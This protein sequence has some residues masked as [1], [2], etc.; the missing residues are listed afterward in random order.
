MEVT[1]K[2][3]RDVQFREKLRG[4]YHPEDVD[5]FLEQAAVG[6]EA[7]LAHLRE[8]E[9]RAAR[10]ERAAAEAS[11]SD[12]TLKRV[13]VMAQRTADQAVQE[14]R[15]EAERLLE[16]AKSKAE[17]LLADAEERGRSAY[18]RGLAESRANLEK[19]EEALRR[20]EQEAEALR[21]WVDRQRG[22]LLRALEAARDS[23]QKAGLTGEPPPSRRSAVGP[24]GPEP[25]VGDAAGGEHAAAAAANGGEGAFAEVP[26]SD[27]WGPGHLSGLGPEPVGSG[28]AAGQGSAQV[29]EEGVAGPPP[30][31][32]LAG[33]GAL[34]G[35]ARM[36]FDEQA[37]ESFFSD[38]DLGEERGLGRFRRRQ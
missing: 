17:A 37:L 16:E 9:E 14:A 2:A 27:E 4:G 5:E 23:V 3:F 20:A 31:E 11:A 36:P 13:L 32:E 19:A 10:A 6:V 28:E 24:A 15:E 25:S 30:G 22:Q 35:E 38:Q 26:A 34:A 21:E 18:E 1:P 29:V 7:L 8:A 12:D 33:A